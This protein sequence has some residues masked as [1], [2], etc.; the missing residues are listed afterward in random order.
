MQH[1]PDHELSAAARTIL[2]ERHA[3]RIATLAE[4][5]RTRE[6]QGRATGDIAQAA[7]AATFG[8]LDTLVVDMNDVVPGTVDEETGAVTFAD[9][10]GAD[11]YGIIDEIV[12]RA[13]RSGAHIFSA[14]KDDIPGGG[15]LAAILRFAV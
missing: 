10:A 7:R 4:F 6:N 3:G 15:S 2:D 9:A 12:S 11:S 8:A 14:R 1:T 13:L 5:H